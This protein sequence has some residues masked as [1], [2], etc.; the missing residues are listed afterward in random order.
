MNR[1]IWIGIAIGAGIGIAYAVTSRNQKSG[2]DRFDAREMRKKFVNHG[3]DLLD[4]GK[5]MMDR[6]RVIV[7]EGQ[8]VVEDA[9]ELWNRGRKMVRA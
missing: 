3:E 9:G 7:Q 8:K 6:I 5:E 4:R 2:W 1:K